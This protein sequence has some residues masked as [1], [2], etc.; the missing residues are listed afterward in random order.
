MEKREYRANVDVGNIED[1]KNDI[2]LATRYILNRIR[3]ENKGKRL[4]IVMDAAREN[5]Y[6]GTEPIGGIAYLHSVMRTYCSEM[7]FEFVDLTG[8]MKKDYER[9]KIKFNSELDMHWNE[10]GHWFVYKQLA[11]LL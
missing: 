4:I 1:R 3:L 6:N 2:L 7:G 11:A 10:Y 5:I 8:A 9:K